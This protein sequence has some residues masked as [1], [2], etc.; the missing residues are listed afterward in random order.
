MN[1]TTTALNLPGIHHV[2][3]IAGDPKR[4]VDFYTRVLG[5]RLVKKT[6]NFDDPT[7]YHLYYGDS[8]GT[9]GSI[10]TFFPWAGLR[11]GRPGNGQV[12]AT[13]F[14]VAAGSLRFWEARLLTHGVTPSA[15]TN[16]FGEDVLAFTDP[17]GL[18]LE[19]VATTEADTRPAHTHPEIPAANAIR[20]F[21]GVTIAV[22]DAARTEKL[23]VGPM[24]YRTAQ[25]AG[26][27]TRYTTGAGGPGTYVDLLVDSSIPRGLQG[28]GT[29]HHLAFQTPDDASQDAARTTL[30][31][32]GYHVSPVMDRNYFHSIYY[33]EPEGVL[34]EIATNPPGFAVDESVDTLGTALKLPAQYEAQR[35]AIEAALPK[36]T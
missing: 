22:I 21:H 34:F 17:D 13:A 9:P 27:R 4:N 16:R 15:Q 3:A 18:I 6:V 24:G 10:L 33:R 32:L 31:S 28:A 2:T 19:L 1:T 20:G 23:L 25:S 7:T 36:L 12:Y 11:R 8:V 5:L 30:L 35:S 26:G 29:V 14:S